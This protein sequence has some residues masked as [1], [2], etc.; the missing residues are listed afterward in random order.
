MLLFKN[1]TKATTNLTSISPTKKLE[2]IKTTLHTTD[3]CLHLS[4]SCTKR[5][6][7]LAN[8]NASESPTFAVI[9]CHLFSFLN[10]VTIVAVY[11]NKNTKQKKKKIVWKTKKRKKQQRHEKHQKKPSKKKNQNNAQNRSQQM[12]AMMPWSCYLPV[13]PPWTGNPD[14]FLTTFFSSWTLFNDNLLCFLRFFS[15]C[16]ENTITTQRK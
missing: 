11:H 15:N 8:N 7:F 14:A 13:V 5:F 9:T 1:Q 16:Q 12:L 6:G 3:K 4:L 2:L 10:T